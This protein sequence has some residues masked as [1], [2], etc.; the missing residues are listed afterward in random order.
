[1]QK[2]NSGVSVN[3]SLNK[4]KTRGGLDWRVWIGCVA[5]AGIIGLTLSILFGAALLFALP[6]GMLF[7]FQK[8]ARIF[9]LWQLSFL[10]NSYYDPGKAVRA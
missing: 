3:D 10:Q 7:F 2:R 8:D 5:I 9:Q 1:M 6:A 4:P